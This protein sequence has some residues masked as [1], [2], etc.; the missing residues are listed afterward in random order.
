M[1]INLATNEVLQKVV[2]IQYK[3]S[4]GTAFAVENDSI[5]KQYLI[6]AKHIFIGLNEGDIFDINVRKNNNWMR[7]KVRIYFSNNHDVDVAVLSLV[8][9]VNIKLAYKVALTSADLA[10]SQDVFFLGFPFNLCQMV[11]D[12]INEGYPLPLV[13]KACLSAFY[14][15]GNGIEQLILDG[16]NNKGFSGGPVC[17]KNINSG[18]FSICGVISGY[19]PYNSRL[20]TPQNVES[21][22]Y[23]KEN[24]GIII[25]YN[26][27]YA[28]EIIDRLS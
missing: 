25:S 22:Y 13:K 10:L 14:N 9:V 19:L 17:F 24:A 23:V 12:D 28:K 18:E 21:D 5:T 15:N 7:L 3:N 8:D 16:I 2:Q 26:I 27:I 4:T 11:S 1:N 20:F 6:T